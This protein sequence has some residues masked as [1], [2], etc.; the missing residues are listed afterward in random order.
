[1]TPSLRS[2]DTLRVSAVHPLRV[3]SS[4]PKAPTHPGG[5]LNGACCTRLHDAPADERGAGALAGALGGARCLLP[6]TAGPSPAL[7][8]SRAGNARQPRVARARP[9]ASATRRAPRREP[10]SLISLSSTLSLH[11]A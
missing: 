9:R 7:V 2:A 3:G 5:A 1:M 10:C 11:G 4:A 6:P 8:S